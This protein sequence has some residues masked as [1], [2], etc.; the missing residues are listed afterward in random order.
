M[1]ITLLKCLPVLLLTFSFSILSDAQS[2]LA[3]GEL[4]LNGSAET[5]FS[6][7]GD[8][9][10]KP[11]KPKLYP[12]AGFGLGVASIDGQ[13]G[14]TFTALS[15][16]RASQVSVLPQATYWNADKQTNFE[17]GVVSQFYITSSPVA[18]YVDFGLGVN[19]YD[20]DTMSF[21]KASLIAGAGLEFKNFSKEFAFFVDF[22]YKL[23]ASEQRNIPCFLVTAG[24][25][26]PFH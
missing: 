9:D 21:T 23:I 16:I 4:R 7:T 13:V 3:S 8:K 2:Q 1:N 6:N 11:R 20:S 18:P 22:K 12:S 26:F 14:F 17:L 19:F 15:E 24:M 10:K 5:Q 25:K